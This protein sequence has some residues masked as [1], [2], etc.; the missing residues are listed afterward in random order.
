[1]RSCLSAFAH[2]AVV[3]ASLF[4]AASDAQAQRVALLIGNANYATAP[5]TNPPND[6]RVMEAAL[7]R[8]H[9]EEAA[10]QA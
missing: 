4:F 10:A 9:M 1:M 7:K 8:W 6:V 3:L 5:L 2:L